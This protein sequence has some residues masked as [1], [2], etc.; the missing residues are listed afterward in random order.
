MSAI[1]EQLHAPI[2]KENPEATEDFI[3]APDYGQT[4]DV[5]CLRYY[6]IKE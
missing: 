1:P 6:K 5:E 4:Q 2:N 3:C